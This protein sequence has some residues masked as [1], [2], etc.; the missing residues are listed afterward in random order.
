MY[1]LTS[2][3]YLPWNN[4]FHYRLHANSPVEF[5]KTYNNDLDYEISCCHKRNRHW[6]P[7]EL[8]GI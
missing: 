3:I 8:N 7:F 4:I 5:Q 1:E 6:Y 2:P